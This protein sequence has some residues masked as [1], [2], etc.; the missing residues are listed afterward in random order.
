MSY[1]SSYDLSAQSDTASWSDADD[2][3]SWS[4]ADEHGHAFSS[5]EDPVTHHQ[6]TYDSDSDDSISTWHIPIPSTESRDAL[7]LSESVL[8]KWHFLR[9]KWRQRERASRLW[10]A[11]YHRLLG[12]RDAAAHS[13]SASLTAHSVLATSKALRFHVQSLSTTTRL[14]SASRPDALSSRRARCMLYLA[15]PPRCPFDRG[16]C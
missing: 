7:C 8:S 4:D 16:K 2:N 14:S 5:N 10:E 12:W 15:P 9:F 3:A 6:P 13:C 11:R 1:T